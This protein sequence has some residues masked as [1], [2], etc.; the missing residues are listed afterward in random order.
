MSVAER[1]RRRGRVQSAFSRVSS[2]GSRAQRCNTRR[3]KRPRPQTAMGS[4]RVPPTQ[5][6]IDVERRR[7]RLA[8]GG[9]GLLRFGSEVP[10]LER[11]EIGFQPRAMLPLP[12]QRWPSSCKKRFAFISIP[13]KGPLIRCEIVYRSGDFYGYEIL[14][15]TD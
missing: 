7:G 9:T 4:S 11:V 10:R 13:L 14:E 5:F 12:S 6:R 2:V 1:V 15:A 8:S 3:Y